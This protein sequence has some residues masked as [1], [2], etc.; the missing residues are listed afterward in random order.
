LA[1]QNNITLLHQLQPDL[2]QEYVVASEHLREVM[3]LVKRIAAYEASVLIYGESGTGK[4]LLARIIHQIS[5]R[6]EEIFVPVNCGSFPVIFL[7][8]SYL[9]TR[10]GPSP[11]PTARARA[12]LNRPTKAPCFWMRSR[13]YHPRIRLIFCGCWKMVGSAA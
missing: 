6:R 5:P 13:R 7:R 1:K 10:P 3:G 9:A 12:G 2:Y 8:A 11:G 4:E